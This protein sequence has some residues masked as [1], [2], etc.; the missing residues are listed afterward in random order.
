[1]L[2][3]PRALFPYNLILFGGFVLWI[4]GVARGRSERPW[5][6]LATISVFYFLFLIGYV[7]YNS[8]V[9]SHAPFLGVQGRYLFPVLIPAYVVMARF[10]LEPFRRTWQIA[11]VVVISAVFIL[12]D[13]PYFQRNAGPDWFAGAPIEAKSTTDALPSR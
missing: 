3:A 11:I 7:N 12:G 4:R 5:T 2:K 6:Y 9:S 8:Y 1:M 10:L 13:V